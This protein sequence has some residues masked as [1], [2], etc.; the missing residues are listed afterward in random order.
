MYLYFHTWWVLVVPPIP[1]TASYV[2]NLS[3][4]RVLAGPP[5]AGGPFM[6]LY[7]HI[8]WVLA[9][10]PIPWR[11]L[12]FYSIFILEGIGGTANIP[13]A[14]HTYLL[15]HTRGVL[16]VPLISGRLLIHISTFIPESICSAVN[17]RDA[18]V[19]I[20]T[21]TPKRYWR[22]RQYL[23]APCIF[24]L[25][26]MKVFVETIINREYMNLNMISMN[27][28]MHMWMRVV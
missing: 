22:C 26:L 4:T 25:L 20:S 23:V 28:N 10:P 3:Y 1:S 14:C 9:V 16:V 7:F 15:F 12:V 5:I 21:F 18:L 24:W 8:L 17:I 27:L 19:R 6:Y 13:V 11:P 2:S